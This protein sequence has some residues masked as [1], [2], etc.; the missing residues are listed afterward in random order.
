[1][2]EASKRMESLR[3]I[4]LFADLPDD[5]LERILDC[6]TEFDAEKG[7]VLIQRDQPGAGLFV[8]EDGTAVVELRDRR[9]ELGPGEF[10]GE[11]ALLD[12]SIRHIARVAA[13]TPIRCLAIRRDDFEGLLESQ[14]HLAVSMLKVL[15]RRLAKGNQPVP[16]PP[17]PD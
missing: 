17:E 4:P 11:L 12:E 15:A 2:P 5:A 8:I 6:A 9:I 10:I 16:S 3:S 7:H 14:P 13:A 1:M